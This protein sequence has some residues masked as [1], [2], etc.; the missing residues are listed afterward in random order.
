MGDL[1]VRDPLSDDRLKGWRE[2]LGKIQLGG[3]R[4]YGWGRVRLISE[5]KEGRRNGGLTVMGFRWEEGNKNKEVLLCVNK[6]ARLA[7]PVLAD[8]LAEAGVDGPVE[9][10]S[11]WERDNGKSDSIWRLSEVKLVYAPGALAKEDLKLKVN[12]RGV[13]QMKDAAQRSSAP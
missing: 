5:L 13:L 10:L 7:S 12:Y 3:E 11:G 8:P 2:A 1:W 6:G 4:A 9:V